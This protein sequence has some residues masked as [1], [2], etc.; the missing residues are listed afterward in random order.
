MQVTGLSSRRERPELPRHTKPPKP[1]ATS[2][3]AQLALRFQ[4]RGRSRFL[5]RECIVESSEHAPD[6]SPKYSHQDQDDSESADDGGSS[7]E[8][9]FQ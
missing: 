2:Y 9:D 7:R 6:H 5:T 4:I 1:I 8:I 3:L